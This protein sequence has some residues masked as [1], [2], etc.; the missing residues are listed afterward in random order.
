MSSQ[1]QGCQGTP[2]AWHSSVHV[3]LVGVRHGTFALLHE[4][5]AC[6]GGWQHGGHTG[7]L[8]QGTF[9]IQFAFEVFHGAMA[10][11]GDHWQLACG[12]RNEGMNA[13]YELCRVVDIISAGG[14]GSS[15]GGQKS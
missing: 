1:C 10:G 11:L 13:W 9:E 5:K 3:H 14:A 6:T 15:I 4:A 8:V 7:L 12:A 2:V